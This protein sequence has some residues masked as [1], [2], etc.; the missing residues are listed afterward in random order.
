M[1]T[2][3]SMPATRLLA[4]TIAVAFAAAALTGCSSAGSA[5]VEQTTAEASPHQ[6]GGDSEHNDADEMFVTMMLEHH[7][8]AITMSDMLIEASEESEASEKSDESGKTGSA[9]DL[10]VVDLARQITD[11]QGPEID[12]L[13]DWSDEWGLAEQHDDAG[14]GEQMDGMLSEKQLS[15]LDDAS[16]AEAAELFLS[17]MIEHH[18]GAV[19]MARDETE[20]GM[21]DAAVDMA[22]EIV[23]SQSGEIERMREMLDAL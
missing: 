19:D 12:I 3:T 5:P 15:E 23:E 4:P 17:G 9:I 11:A 13:T 16:G 21:N 7:K 2:R 22:E 8:Q 10:D 1:K 14:D 18:E 6:Q 20:N